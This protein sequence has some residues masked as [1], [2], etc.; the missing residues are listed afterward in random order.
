MLRAS[1]VA[2]AAL[3][4]SGTSYLHAQVPEGPPPSHNPNYP[5]LPGAPE[6]K[7]APGAPAATKQETL[8]Q[9]QLKSPRYKSTSQVPSSSVQATPSAKTPLSETKPHTVTKRKHHATHKPNATS[10]TKPQK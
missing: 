8:K 6:Y 10:T 7:R 5:N 1:I 9:P 3:I 2:L 4:F